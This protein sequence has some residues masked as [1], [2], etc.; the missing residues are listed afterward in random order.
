MPGVTTQEIDDRTPPQRIYLPIPTYGGSPVP[1]AA[2]PF[3]L[4]FTQGDDFSIDIDFPFDLSLYAVAAQIR[5]FPESAAIIATPT[6][7][8]IDS[9]LRKVRLSLSQDQTT[10]CPLR[11]YW[12]AQVTGPSPSEFTETYINGMVFCKRQVTR[13]QDITSNPSWSPTG[14]EPGP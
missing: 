2:E 3:D 6:L 13:E 14:W 9:G 4:V 1:S 7:T 10:R 11:A 5:L 12:D 8:V